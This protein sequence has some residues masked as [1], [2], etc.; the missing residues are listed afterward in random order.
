MKLG[1]SES[2]IK[3]CNFTIGCYC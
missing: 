1:S 2:I 3:A